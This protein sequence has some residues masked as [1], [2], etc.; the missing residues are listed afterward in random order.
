[1][2]KHM[3]LFTLDRMTEGAV[4]YIECDENGRPKQWRDPSLVSGTLYLRKSAIKSGRFP[5][6]IKVE[7]D[8]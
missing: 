5:Q 3:T 6:Q 7:I 4:K 8:Y 1:M 2:V